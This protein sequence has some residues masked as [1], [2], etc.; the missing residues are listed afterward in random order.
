MPGSIYSGPPPTV[1]AASTKA[2]ISE[3]SFFPYFTCPLYFISIL[4]SVSF[5]RLIYIYIYI[6]IVFP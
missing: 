1:A 5:R 2:H 4:D 6:Y 3:L